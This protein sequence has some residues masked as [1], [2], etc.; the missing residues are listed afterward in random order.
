IR[1]FRV[2]LGEIEAVLAQHPA[3]RET[4]IVARQGESGR[5]RLT[6]Y[7]STKTGESVASGDL[8]EYV[9]HRLPEY[10]IPSAFV[11]LDALP[12]TPNG[13][14]DRLALPEADQ[15]NTDSQSPY[16][17]PRNF[18]EKRVAEIWAQVLGVNQIGI[19]DNFFDLGGHS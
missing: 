19:H 12:H 5:K 15:A 11:R 1:G 2:E 6:A 7:V 14:I 13:K 9:K 8:R 4:A 17:A 16:T 18:I 10:M 3:I